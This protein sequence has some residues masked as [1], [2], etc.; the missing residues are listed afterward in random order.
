MDEI[1]HVSSDFDSKNDQDLK[2]RLQTLK[3]LQ[4]E[5]VN[6]EMDFHRNFYALDMEY[7]KKRQAI[8]ERRK[9]I[10]NGNGDCTKQVAAEIV[11]SVATALDKMHLT[12]NY[13][14]NDTKC[15][16]GIPNFWFHVFKN[17]TRND[18]FIHQCD[19]NA[20]HY[21]DDVRV[22][23]MNEPQFAFTLEFEFAP[24]PYFDNTILTK[25]Y[26]LSC[27][28]DDIFDGF[29]V[30]KT[31]GCEINWMDGMNIVKNEGQ[32][33]FQFFDPPKFVKNFDSNLD[34]NE[35]EMKILSK[36]QQDFEIGLFIKGKLIPKAVLYYLNEVDETMNIF[37]DDNETIRVEF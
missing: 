1:G 31:L 35:M 3:M 22:K 30:I 8:C 2:N 11:D 26:I 18:D 28:N 6:I 20:L 13:T 23:L 33:F 21:L 9:D 7:Q 12:Q 25:Q 36:L 14:T 15:G 16:K 17:C 24:N 4:I 19:E 29:S 27:D 32:T 34:L 5:Y 37:D 10:I